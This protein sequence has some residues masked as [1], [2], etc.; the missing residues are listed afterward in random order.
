MYAKLCHTSGGVRP[1][2]LYFLYFNCFQGSIGSRDQFDQGFNFSIFQFFKE[3]YLFNSISI[4][5]R[6]QLF[7]GLY[8]FKGSIGAR[9]GGGCV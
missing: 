3:L 5:S 1:Y 6:D 7:Q 9:V 8:Y 2:F 4:G